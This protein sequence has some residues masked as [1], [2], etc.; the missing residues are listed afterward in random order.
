M[1][2]LRLEISGGVLALHKGPGEGRC[3]SGSGKALKKATPVGSHTAPGFARHQPGD[4]GV[5][6]ITCFLFPPSGRPPFHCWTFGSDAF[7][8]C[9]KNICCDRF[10]CASIMNESVRRKRLVFGEAPEEFQFF[11]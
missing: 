9:K 7:Y 1:G 4:R 3:S 10:A 8:F 2:G 6:L 5:K 11:A